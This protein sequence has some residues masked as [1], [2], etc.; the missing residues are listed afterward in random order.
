MAAVASAGGRFAAGGRDGPND[1]RRQGPRRLQ[2][3]LPPLPRPG[4]R[5]RG[6]HELHPRPRQA[7]R[8]Q[9]DRPRPARSVAAVQTPLHG[10]DAARRRNA[11]PLRGRYRRR[12]AVDRTGARRRLALARRPILTD[13]EAFNR[14]LADLDGQDRP[15]A[16]S[17]AISASPR[18]PT[19]GPARTNCRPTATPS[20]SCSTASPGTRASPCR[21]RSTRISTILRIDLRD[22]QWDANL[23]NRL[24][25]E[26]PYGILD[27]TAAARAVV[28]GTATRVPLR[29]GRLVPGQRVA[30]A[31]VLRPAANSVQFGGTGAAAARRCG[32]GHAAGARGAGRLPRLRHLAQQPPHRAARRHERRLLAD[33]RF[34]GDPA[35]P[36]R[37]GS[38]LARPPQPVRLS[39]RPRPGRRQRLPARGRRGHFQPAQRLAGLL[40]R[41]RQRHAAGQGQHGHRQRSEAARPRRGGRRVVHVL[42]R[43]RHQPQ[44]RPDPRPRW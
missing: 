17:S 35:E 28:I 27:D 39:A 32:D 10:Q 1:R 30:G 16:A 36:R 18:S 12:Q 11:A 25:A 42:S 33:L 22:Y 15:R 41:Q 40:P 2:R 24:L 21:R 20:P 23:W 14:I 34:R 7:R 31:A 26:Y 3:Q 29:A 9:K 4:R 8:P 6:R 19:P 38:A 13:A 43:P 37:S 5:R 44:G